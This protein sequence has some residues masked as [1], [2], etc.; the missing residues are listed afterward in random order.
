MCKGDTGLEIVIGL[1]Q[2]F[3]FVIGRHEVFIGVGFALFAFR[4]DDG[5]REE[6]R[7][8]VVEI[9]IEVLLVEAI[10]KQRPTLRQM[11]IAEDLAHDGAVFTFRQGVIVAVA[12]PGLG[13]FDTEFFR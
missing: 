1:V 8:M 9:R 3:E 10:D 5:V 13:E 2:G 7:P 4:I 11:G 12:G 6:T